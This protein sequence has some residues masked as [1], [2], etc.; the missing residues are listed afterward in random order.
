MDLA[1]LLGLGAVMERGEAHPSNLD[2]DLRKLLLFA[3]P[4]RNQH[5]PDRLAGLQ[6]RQTILVQHRVGQADHLL[7][8]VERPTPNL[9]DM[10]VRTSPVLRWNPT[11]P[12]Y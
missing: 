10:V 4:S 5:V 6:H 12:T 8:M 11:C 9:A 1:A 2:L 3:W 7:Y